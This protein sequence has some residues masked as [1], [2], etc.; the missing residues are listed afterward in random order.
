MDNNL[1]NAVIFVFFFWVIGGVL[2]VFENY[3]GDFV[4]MVGNI[5]R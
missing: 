5:M 2:Y 1:P 4:C 3:E